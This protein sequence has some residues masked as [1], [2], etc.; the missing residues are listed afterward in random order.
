[1]KPFLFGW[2]KFRISWEFVFPGSCYDEDHLHNNSP[3]SRTNNLKYLVS[4]CFFLGLSPDGAVRISSTN[5]N[6]KAYAETNKFDSC[7]ST[8]NGGSLYFSE[9]G[10]FVQTKNSYINSTNTGLGP[11]FYIWVSEQPNYKDYTNETTVYNCGSSEKDCRIL[12]AMYRGFCIMNEC[13][14]TQNRV[15]KDCGGYWVQEATSDSYITCVN[16]VENNQ[17]TGDF[18]HHSSY[19]D[20]SSIF[21]VTSCN[22]IRNKSPDDKSFLIYSS[23]SDVFMSYCCILQNEIKYIFSVYPAITFE[24]SI[25]DNNKSYGSSPIFKNTDISFENECPLFKLEV[26]DSLKYKCRHSTP[27]N[28]ENEENEDKFYVRN[29]IKF[30]Y[31]LMSNKPFRSQI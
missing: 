17:S 22:Y 18:N 1:M 10:E 29:H 27:N 2:P 15:K 6:V 20:S 16:V 14:I 4:S 23:W 30:F 19:Y 3:F 5:D 12:T 28:E 8:Q 21:K 26:V 9:K 7:S 13:N 25:T 11:S 24:N 31:L